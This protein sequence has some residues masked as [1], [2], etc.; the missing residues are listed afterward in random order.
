[1]D[2]QNF[3]P[4]QSVQNMNVRV[5]ISHKIHFMQRI[6]HLFGPERLADILASPQPIILP[7]INYHV[8]FDVC[9][10]ILL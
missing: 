7:L 2:S 1:M 3:F 9:I 6:V 4:F 10:F 8:S 5:C